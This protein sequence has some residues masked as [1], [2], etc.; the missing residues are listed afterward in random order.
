MAF[1]CKDELNYFK[2]LAQKQH[3]ILQDSADCGLAYSEV[4]MDEVRHNL[5]RMMGVF[6][7]D[8]DFYEYETR[9]EG[10]DQ[11]G[12]REV[13]FFVP[14]E[15]EQ[16]FYRGVRLKIGRYWGFSSGVGPHGDEGYITIDIQ[17]HRKA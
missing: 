15:E 11:A 16:D 9:V 10:D 4:S 1:P 3:R 14:I 6:R 17:D 2:Q 5:L 7:Q 12:M 13:S 8:P